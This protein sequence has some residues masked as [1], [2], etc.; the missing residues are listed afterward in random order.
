[1]KRRTKRTNQ[2]Y[3]IPMTRKLLLMALLSGIVPLSYAQ[4]AKTDK[5][6]DEMDAI[7]QD[8]AAFVFTESQ[9]GEDDEMTQN[10]IM[11]NSNNNVY[12]SNVG[13]LFSPARY[14]YRAY[15]SRYNDI[16]FNGV[17][18]NN[19][20]SGQ[21]NYSTIGGMND[22]T[23]SIDASGVFEANSFS[24]T[25]IGGSSNYNFRAS[26]YAAGHK[27]TLSGANR[28]YTARAMYNFGTGVTKNGWAFFGSLGHLLL[29]YRGP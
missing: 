18:V 14:K 28:N 2:Q 26:N 9:L 16:Y 22:A 20:E 23:R 24:M 6:G 21:F 17:L 10:V 7:R 8:N 13:Y 11:V 15:N 27:V 29:L 3:K 5:V 4:T 1:M 12:T 25:N 19:A